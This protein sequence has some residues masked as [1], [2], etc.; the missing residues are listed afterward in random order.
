MR[1]SRLIDALTAGIVDCGVSFVDVDL[2]CL[3]AAKSLPVHCVV[4]AI[5][6]IVEMR[7]GGARDNWRRPHVETDTYVFIP[8]AMPFQVKLGFWS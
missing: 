2:S 7:S 6:S 5:H 1:D 3:F 8:A 4:E